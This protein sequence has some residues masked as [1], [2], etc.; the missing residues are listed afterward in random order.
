MAVHTLTLCYNSSDTVSNNTYITAVCLYD[1]DL[2]YSPTAS[3]S[4]TVHFL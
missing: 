3:A 2:N 4:K 1:G